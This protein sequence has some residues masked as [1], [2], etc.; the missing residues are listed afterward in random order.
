MCS[1]STKGRARLVIE[2]QRQRKRWTEEKA[3]WTEMAEVT[4]S[5]IVNLAT[6]L[7]TCFS[8][9]GRNKDTA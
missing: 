5:V 7:T 2:K 1:C 9:R 8:C 6:S 4:I 3:A